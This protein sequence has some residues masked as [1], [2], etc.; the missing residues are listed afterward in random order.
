MSSIFVYESTV[1]LKNILSYTEVLR[2]VLTRPRDDRVTFKLK[3]RLFFTEVSSVLAH[4]RH[5]K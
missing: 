5:S 3:K 2:Q 4:V 1:F